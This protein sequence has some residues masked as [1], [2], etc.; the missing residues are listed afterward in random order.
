M[1]W[2]DQDSSK[3]DDY[4]P[5][6]LRMP[7]RYVPQGAA[8]SVDTLPHGR[9]LERTM[10]AIDIASEYVDSIVI[11]RAMLPRHSDPGGPDITIVA[12]FRTDTIWEMRDVWGTPYP[13]RRPHILKN[14]IF[15]F[16]NPDKADSTLINIVVNS[17]GDTTRDSSQYNMR[18]HAIDSLGVTLWYH[19]TSP[20]AL[21]SVMLVTPLTR[22]A[23]SGWYDSSWHEAF[24]AHRTAMQQRFDTVQALSGH[25][26]RALS[27]YTMSS[28]WTIC[29]A[30][31][32]GATL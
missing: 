11:T 18:Y 30:C 3:P 16:P 7:F 28:I 1:R 5:K 32:I 27:F 9:G 13:Y 19:G 2:K 23:T 6:R 4:M 15:K 12:E 20:V 26:V 29:G 24:A 8:G 21:R 25:R 10:H 22:R 14:G 17:S 31:A